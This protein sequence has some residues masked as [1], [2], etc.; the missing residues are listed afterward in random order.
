M[1]SKTRLAGFGSHAAEET[2]TLIRRASPD[3]GL[4][5]QNELI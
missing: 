2:L 1:A 4:R 3:R 5:R